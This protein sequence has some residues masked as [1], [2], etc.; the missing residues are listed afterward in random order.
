MANT[1]PGGVDLNTSPY[2]DDYDED[3]KFVRVLY[4]PGRAV[5][6]RELSQMQTLQQVQTRRFANYFFK[7]GS[8]IDGCDQQIDL[9]LDY[10]KLQANYNGSEVDVTD[11][12]NKIVYG[13]NSGLKAYCGIVSD[14]EGTDPKTLFINYLSS[15]SI[16]LTVNNAVTTITPGNTIT[17]STGNSAIVE[18][19]YID[20]VTSTNKILVSSANGTL[21]VT[22][23][24]TI[25]STGAT[26][27]LNVTAI[28]DKRANTAFDSN[29]T[30]FTANVTT[31]AYAS[32]ATT[33]ATST[34]VNEGLATEKT[35][36]KGS[37]ITVT[38][39]IIYLADHFIDHTS[40]TL[41]LDKYT[42]EPSYKIG[43]VPNKTFVNYI[44]DPSLVD[45]AQGTPNFQAPGADRLKI[46]T[47]LTKVG[48]TAATDENEFITFVEIENGVAKKRKISSVENKLEEELALRTSEE[49]GDYS[50]SDPLVG[51]RE[52]LLQ[53][54]NGGR[55]TSAEGGNNSLLLLEVDPFT[56]YVSGFRN[57]IIV[58]T[59]VELTKGLTTQ[60]VE[61]TKTQVN[62]GQYLEVKELVGSW[63]FMEGTKV[64][65]YDAVQEAI[66]NGGFSS[67]TLAGSK[68]GEARVR[69]IEYVSGTQGTADARYY[70]YIY[71]IAMNSGKTISQVKSVYDSATPNRLADIVVASGSAGAIPLEQSFNSMVFNLPY[72]AIQTIRDDQQNIET[73][74]RF[75]KRFSVTFTNGLATIA[76]TDSSE[77]FVGTSVLSAT[78]KNEFYMVV[79]N[80]GGANVETGTLTGTVSVSSGTD[81]VTGVGTA[82]TT[83]LN[84]GDV[85]NIASEQISI[86]TITNDTSLTLAANHS[87]GA[88]GVTYTKIL[89]AGRPLSL[90]SYGG[91]G[92]IRSVDVSSPGTVVID[93]KENATFTADVITTMDRTN[94]REKRKTLVYQAT[95]NINPNTY[96]V[97]DTNGAYLLGYADVYQIHA[98]YQSADFSTPATTS[99]TD[100]TSSYT[101]DNGQR[102]YAYEYGR[103]TPNAGVTPTGRLLVVFD[104]F[105]HDTTQGVGYCSVDSYPVNDTTTS[106][107]TINTADIPVFVSPSTKKQFNL[108]DC[109]DFRPIKTAN[110]S[111]NPIDVGTYQ[112]PT[113]GLH[114]PKPN[115]DF[116]AD[117]I[118]YK[119]RISKVFI[120]S[121]GVFGINEGVPAGT[122]QLAKAPPRIADTL[123]LAEITVPPYPSQPKDVK[124]KLLKNR[125]FTMKD[126]SKINDRVKNLEYF[127]ML[128]YLE[129]Q[130]NEKTIT[131]VDGFD[132]FKNGI[133]VDTFSGH[134]VEDV[135]NPDTKS[136]IDKINRYLTC[137]QDNAN[138]T[139]MSYNSA[140]SETTKATGNKVLMTYTT[141]AVDT[142]TQPYA[143]RQL[144]LAEEL[145]TVWNGDMRIYPFA[146][147]WIHTDPVDPETETIV[148]ED[149]SNADNWRALAQAWNSEVAPLNVHFLN[150][151]QNVDVAGSA[152]E[153]IEGGQFVTRVAVN[154]TQTAFN[155]LVSVNTNEKSTAQADFV[156]NL[157][158]SIYMRS[159]DFV[160]HA[161][162]LKNNS[163][164][165]AFFDGVDVTEHCK[166]IRLIGSEQTELDF[167][168]AGLLVNEGTDWEEIADGATDDLIVASNEIYILFRVP[169]KTFYVG[170]REFKLTDSATNGTA[171]TSAKNSLFAQFLTQNMGRISYNS[172][173]TTVSFTDQSNIRELGRQVIGSAGT[174][175]TG[176]R[177]I[178]RNP[179]PV[180]QSFFVDPETFPDGF[181]LTSIDLFFSSVPSGNSGD[182]DLGVRVEIREMINGFPS[183]EI[184]GTGDGA[185]L[186]SPQINTSADATVATTF[187]MKNPIYLSPG[188]EYCF[189][190]K[191]DGNDEDFA[192]WV[193][194][195]GA[196]DITNPE[197]DTVIPPAYGAGV[198]FTSAN[199]RTWSARQ[200]LD[201]KFTIKCAVF[202]TTATQFAYFS[203]KTVSTARSYDA[204]QPIFNDL[205]L[206]GTNIKYEI[207]TADSSFTVDEDWT[208]VKDYERFILPSRKQIS[209]ESD[210]TANSFK[211]LQVRATLTTT[212]QYISPYIDGEKTDFAISRN[213]IN[214][215][216]STAVDGTVEYASG[217]SLV[218]G[219]G[220]DFA[221]DVFAG[222]YVNFGNDQYRRIQSITNNNFLTVSTNFT[223]SNSAAQTITIRNEENPSG[224]YSS[225]SRYI[226]RVVTL[227][228]GFEAADLVVY[229]NVNRPPG[230]GIRVYGKFLNESD[231]DSFDDKFYTLMSL[232]GTETFTLDT[233]Q[234]AEEKYIIPTTS[235]TGGAELLNGTVFVSSANTNVEGTSTR[236]LQELKIGDTI[237]VGAARTERTITT[238]ANNTFLTVDSAFPSNS[239]GQDVYRILNNEVVYT[240]PDD[241]TFSG[242]K[243]F[244]IKIVFISSSENY[245]PK[246]KDFR[247]IALA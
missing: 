182:A 70:L 35:Y 30:I 19:S 149:T 163:I 209:T 166:Q 65:L 71:E 48:L 208:E 14:I 20:P 213:V 215:S 100:V 118:Y 168:N 161:T 104:H 170:Q 115:S 57:Q 167:D 190:M 172:R 169:A 150:D 54:V 32:S 47:V 43:I 114:I 195:L 106:N 187:T 24:S 110:T 63:D 228:D 130:A 204:I 140:T 173:P 82:F 221:N 188:N 234:Y 75:K 139:G 235:K 216:L 126:I 27:P 94:A 46:N 21:T 218:F 105:T 3:K 232:D 229:L 39:G 176:T 51:V 40:Q 184:V 79:V 247:A 222:E 84:V 72:S 58:Q 159:R 131:D 12:E 147:N 89:H 128:V 52:H 23:A 101:F 31:R 211:S 90:T 96:P 107:T 28:N 205:V 157:I 186:K 99:D 224:P 192:I 243:N 121:R 38:D 116:D 175:I 144:R 231:T 62:Y 13:A 230:T 26:I 55:Y 162:G 233:A 109:I 206:P 155:Q 152:R 112:V 138:V 202:D 133:L 160:I 151:T 220:T 217:T 83:E 67:Q 242:F 225:E 174:R 146:D 80:N 200:N 196:T 125:R 119:G 164:M 180:S 210:E 41:I 120:N 141:E 193:A 98:I 238:I 237:G 197:L 219:T 42:N 214:N 179:D 245:A 191:P 10:V 56:A 153:T 25:D 127:T 143:S 241:R 93:V 60:F 9:S 45:N 78:Q 5:Q 50:L 183:A 178:P 68:I 8:I 86:S 239:S 49:S 189:T 1:N 64:D 135:R 18:A 132:R 145:A 66:T 223:S 69:A 207:K 95:A 76:T 136:S 240:T 181:F 117:L 34:V 134:S 102:D 103:I 113:G 212:N 111:L 148:F 171:L 33:R 92:S 59:P 44:S 53:G 165:Y 198:L 36:T 81:A 226:T 158:A 29:E 16:V 203:N 129:K 246:V 73:G 142:L 97:A 74:F 91:D 11:F 85:I 4:V 87:G 15:G 199:D 201:A 227:N 37:K 123:E 156:Q 108:R 194:E 154:Q 244:A 61:Q 122:N 6:A 77:N 236:F 7:Q 22:T 137:I 177:P 2:F 88:S 17:F 124:I 185:Y